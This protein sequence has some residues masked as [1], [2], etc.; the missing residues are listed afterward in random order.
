MDTVSERYAESLFELALEN[1]TVKAYLDDI[2]LVDIVLE[3]DPEFVVFFSHVLIEDQIKYQLLEDSFKDSV[4]HYILNFLKLLVK[5]RRIRYIRE[6]V[7]A[8]IKLCNKQLGI[9]EGIIYSAFDLTDKQINSIARA[10]SKKE[11]KTVQLRVIKDE[12]LIGGVRVQ[13]NTRVYDG[14]VK[15]KV[16]MLKHSLLESR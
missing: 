15:N 7:K 16:N 3:S 11:N 10:I 9:E 12:S 14:S 5:K 13:V 6:I 4:D 8:F 2:K 1:N